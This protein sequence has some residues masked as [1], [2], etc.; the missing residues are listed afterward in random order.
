MNT[1]KNILY[2]ILMGLVFLGAM[3]VGTQANAQSWDGTHIYA[4]QYTKH[5]KGS[6]MYAVKANGSEG[7]SEGFLLT[8]SSKG[9]HFTL[10]IMENSYGDFS[11]YGM[12]GVSL[13]ETKSFQISAHVGYATNYNKAYLSKKNSA[14]LYK[15]L[16]ESMADASYM[17]LFTMT[18]K[19]R[20]TK[21]VGVQVN[22]SPMFVN[23]GLYVQL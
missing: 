19:H 10:G 3:L 18:Y 1:I 20:I 23:T 9:L 14:K 5:Y 11:R 21:N 13:K 15:Y 17:P 12:F 16:P 8:R 6:R 22:V 2:T 4:P 7:G